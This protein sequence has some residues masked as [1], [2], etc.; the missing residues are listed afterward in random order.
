LGSLSCYPPCVTVF[1]LGNPAEAHQPSTVFDRADEFGA[2]YEENYRL[3]VGTVRDHFYI[4]EI[5]AEGLAHEVFL[6]YFLKADEVSNSRAWLLSAIFNA[7]RAYMR[8]RARHVP[9]PA[10]FDQ[11]RSDPEFAR[12]SE[13]LPDQMAAREAFACVT[14]RCQI[15]LR[16]RYL[17]G[18]SIPEVATELNTSSKYAAKLVSRCLR[19]AQDRYTKRGER[20]AGS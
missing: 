18:Y 13:A 16:L 2:I 10:A 8:W 4:S 11:E 14:A 9:L 20:D 1:C 7:G 15:A 3:L 5:D 12:I 17:E 6:A 19:Q